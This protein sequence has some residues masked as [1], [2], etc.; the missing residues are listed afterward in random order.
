MYPSRKIA[1]A[2]LTATLVFWLLRILV[3]VLLSNLH[4]ETDMR[5]RSTFVHTHLVLLAKG[6]AYARR[7]VGLG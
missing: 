5:A 3:R 2:V 7:C 6:V 1:V 4:L